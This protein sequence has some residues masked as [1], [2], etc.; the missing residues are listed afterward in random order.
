[1]GGGAAV[2]GDQSHHAVSGGGRE[3]ELGLSSTVRLP[4]HA[5]GTAAEAVRRGKGGW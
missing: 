5:F 3:R 2:E 4:M 1:M